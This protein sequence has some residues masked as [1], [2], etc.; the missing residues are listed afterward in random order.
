MVVLSLSLIFTRLPQTA[1]FAAQQFE[2]ELNQRENRSCCH[3]EA[4]KASSNWAEPSHR[5]CERF[6]IP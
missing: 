2:D 1:L 4:F 3:G 6:F 5:T